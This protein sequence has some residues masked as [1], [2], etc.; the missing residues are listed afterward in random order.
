[1]GLTNIVKKVTDEIGSLER[2]DHIN[3]DVLKIVKELN[4]LAQDLLAESKKVED[5]VE[6]AIN[7]IDEAYSQA[8]DVQY[9]AKEAKEA[10][11]DLEL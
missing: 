7:D 9:N 1:L 5:A 6:Q 10:L 3:N 4:V 8:N 2:Y 11:E